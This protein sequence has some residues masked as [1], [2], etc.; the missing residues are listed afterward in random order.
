MALSFDDVLLIPQHSNINSR[1]EVDLT[2]KIS[3]SL[4]L[5]IPLISTNMTTVTGV[6][7]AIKMSELGGMGILP[8]FEPTDSQ[9]QK[10]AQIAAKNATA[11]ASVGIKQGLQR[12]QA[13]VQAGA[14]VLNIDVAHGHMQQNLDFTKKLKN[15]FGDKITLLAGIA[16]TGDCALDLYKAGADCVLVGIGGGSICTTRIQTGCGLPT[17]ESLTRINDVARKQNKTFIPCA[18]I[19]N[20]GDIVKSLAAGASAI[21]A[22]SLFAGADETPGQTVQVNGKTY[23]QYNGSTSLAEKTQHLEKVPEGKSTAYA[24]HIEGVAAMVE[25]KGPVSQVVEG[26]LAGIRSGLSYCGAKNIP[27]L[28]KKAQFTKIT[29]GGINESKPHDVFVIE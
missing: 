6:Q 24:A 4:T 10:V 21:A 12:A 2:T 8:R 15:H 3:P 23:K 1:S 11:A 16:S 27:Q 22:G 25:H 13:L 20:S 9:A 17:F 26:L 29:P 14:T 5:K 7:M 28:W 18:G 19:R